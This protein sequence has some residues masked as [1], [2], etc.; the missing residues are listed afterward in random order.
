MIT[1]S[2]RP[3]SA[4]RKRSTYD[5][6][7]GPT[8]SSLGET[9]IL[10]PTSRPGPAIGSS[11]NDTQQLSMEGRAG[12]NHPTVRPEALSAS[13]YDIVPTIA[14][15]QSTSINVVTATPDFRWVFSGG[16]DGYIR[17]FN[18]ADTAN[19][20]LMLTVAQRHPFVDSVV[21]AGVLSSYWENEESTAKSGDYGSALSPVYSLAVHRNALWLLS[22]LESGGINL[23]TVRHEE[24]KRIHCLKQHTSAVSVLNLAQDERSVLSGS[25]DK[26]VFD[27]DLD[28]G[29]IKRRFN[30]NTGQISAIEVRPLSNLPVPEYSRDWL[31]DSTTMMSDSTNKPKANG[32]LMNESGG[33][34]LFDLQTEPNGV[35]MSVPSPADSLF[36][37]NDNDSLFGDHGDDNLQ[38]GDA[39]TFGEDYDDE[40]SRAIASGMQQGANDDHTLDNSIANVDAAEAAPLPNGVSESQD[41]A[42]DLN[43]SSQPQPPTEASH[44]QTNGL[45]HIEDV[46]MQVSSNM[47]VPNSDAGEQPVA[48]TVFLTSSINGSIRIWDKRTSEPIA[49]VLAKNAPPWCMGACWSPDGNF[50]YAGRRN[51]TV[52]EFSL[53]KGF[54]NA[55]RTFRFPQGSGPV[56]ALR[57]MPNGRHLV[58]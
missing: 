47:D 40:F 11:E 4:L 51:G 37:G 25:W 55:E 12:T 57:A 18:W 43:G 15:P 48:D 22:G 21:K 30:G 42:L 46:E 34:D 27:W 14:A 7:T 31:T 39:P 29:Q 36:G 44:S 45:P 3:G 9:P 54:R 20:K 8:P 56:S 1:D 24:G 5:S 19:G 38:N 53:H 10:A 6:K 28:T 58:W 23:Q 35:P 26:N 2:Q 49:K 52:E 33:Q 41:Y 13:T 17:K 32:S 50:I 16:S